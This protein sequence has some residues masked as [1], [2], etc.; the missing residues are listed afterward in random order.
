MGKRSDFERVERDFY[1]TPYAAVV[2]LFPHLPKVVRFHE[3]C[4]GEGDLAASLRSYGHQLGGHADIKWGDI[5]CALNLN[6]CDGDMFITNP[7]YDWK[8]LN[9]LITHLSDIAETWLL[10]PADMMHNVRMGPHMRRCVM[11][12]SVGRVKWFGNQAGKENSAW[13]LFD[14][15]HTGPTTFVGRS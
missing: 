13:Y 15:I 5:N 6:E 4:Y 7:P 12:V 10:L 11:V 9:P 3:P 8:L 14:A 1:P 2:P